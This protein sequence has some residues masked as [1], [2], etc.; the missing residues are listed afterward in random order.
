MKLV[1]AHC[2][3]EIGEAPEGVVV[4]CEESVHQLI[5]EIQEYDHFNFRRVLTAHGVDVP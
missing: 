5:K 3:K 2:K 1:C 4:W